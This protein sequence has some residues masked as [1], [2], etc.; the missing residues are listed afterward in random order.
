MINA[1]YIFKTDKKT[2]KEQ[3]EL[4]KKV[5]ER[6]K[7]VPGCHQSDIWHKKDSG[8]IMLFE[9]WM[10]MNDLKNHIHSPVYKWMLAAIDLSAGEP[11]IRFVECNT[12]TGIDLIKDVLINGSNRKEF[13]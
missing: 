12:I 5:V 11:Q 8:E 7:Y 9:T 10:T 13:T 6:V 4:L 2:A 1:V 3:M